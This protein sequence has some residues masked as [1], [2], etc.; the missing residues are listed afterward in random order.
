MTTLLSE[1]GQIEI[2]EIFRQVDALQPGERGEIKRVGQRE[3]RVRMVASS[4]RQKPV[5]RLGDVLRSCPV[6]RLMGGAGSQGA[7]FSFTVGPLRGMIYLAAANLIC[8]QTKTGFR[9]SY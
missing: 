8:E 9:Y 1:N 6:K 7:H 5:E 2:P 4:T 3:Y